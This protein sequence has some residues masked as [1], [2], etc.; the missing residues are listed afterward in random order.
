[1]IPDNNSNIIF[2]ALIKDGWSHYD[3]S[4]EKYIFFKAFPNHEVCRCN[5]DK[6]SKQVEIYF[7]KNIGHEFEIECVGE[8]DDGSWIT[9]KAHGIRNP[10]YEKLLSKVE[11]LLVSWDKFVV[12]TM[13]KTIPFN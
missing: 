2:D 5:S 10:T 3:F 6:K 1:M 13:V 8:L 11:D 12:L 7:Y 4:F 9:L